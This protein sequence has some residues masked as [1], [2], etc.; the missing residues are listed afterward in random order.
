M[1][2]R[3]NPR[4]T[5]GNVVKILNEDPFLAGAIKW[6]EMSE[7]IDIV[8]NLG[9][10]R[11]VDAICDTDTNNLIL[12]MEKNYGISNGNTIEKAIDIV[13][14]NNR[15]HPVREILKTLKW[16]GVP[17]VENALTHFLGVEKTELTTTALKL[18]MFGAA[19]RMFEPGIKFETSLCLVGDQGAG[20]STFFRL[21]AIKDECFSDD[22]KKLDDE[23][24]YRKMQGHWI[25]EMSEMLAALNSRSVEDIKSFLSRQKDTYKTPYHKHP[26]DRKRQCVFGGTSNRLEVLPMDKSGNRRIIPIE[27]HMDRAEVHILENEA[28]SRAYFLQMWAEIMEQYRSG[29][30]FLTLPAHLTTELVKYQTRFTPE[31]SDAE[32]IEQF[33][34]ETK[35]KYVCVSMLLQEALGYTEYDRPKKNERNRVAETMRTMTGWTEAGQQRFAKYGRQRAWMRIGGENAETDFEPVPEQMKLPFDE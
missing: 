29:N 19:A 13:A 23:N 33:L 22:L 3:G 18:F 10:A 5:I 31:D 28:E 4:Q 1:S 17:R 25:I 16:D 15:Y 24:V 21:L 12:Y 34:E 30:Y 7:T 20:K 35:E 11:D 27:T 2:E 26:K 9:W 32:L 14:N 8:R 6:N